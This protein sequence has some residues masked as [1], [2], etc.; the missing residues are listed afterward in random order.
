MQPGETMRAVVGELTF[1]LIAIALPVSPSLAADEVWRTDGRRVGGALTV[2]EGQLHFQAKEGA[3]VPLADVARIRLA[4]TSSPPFR[5]G[6]GR[7]VRLRDGQCITGQFLELSKDTLTLRTAWSARVELPRASLESIDPLPGWRTIA[8]EDFHTDSTLFKTT[9]GPARVE[10]EEGTGSRAALLREDGQALV[11]TVKQPL[12]AG[13]VGINFQERGPTDGA[14]WVW[15]LLFQNGERSHRLRVSVAGESNHYAIHVDD[16][17]GVTRQVARTPG[18][19]RLMV[20]FSNRSLR[21]TCDDDVLWYNLEHGP[22]GR[23]H[24]V[25][26]RCQKTPGGDAPVRGGVAWTEFCLERA[27]DEHP[28]PPPDPDQETLRLPGDDQLFGRILQA[29]RHTIHVEGRFGKRALPWTEVVGCSFRRVGEPKRAHAREAVRL[30][31]RS[32]LCPE[33]DVLVGVVTALDERKLALH[34]ALLGDLSFDRGSIAELR[35]LSGDA[36]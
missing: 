30:L 34:H 5:V 22:G 13:R 1:V 21:V 26:A 35:P 27:V 36:R 8:E 33:A 4:Q 24:Q 28:Q 14:T 12:P 20:Q 32:G 23:L 6:G 19:H 10:V 7:R 18:R 11:Y 17:N 29:D 2:K 31:V 16:L 25:T 15:E 3:E 9:G